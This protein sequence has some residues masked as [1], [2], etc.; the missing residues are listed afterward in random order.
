MPLAKSSG[1]IHSSSPVRGRFAVMRSPLGSPLPL[2]RHSL[3]LDVFLVQS[4]CNGDLDCACR[5][6]L[7][8]HDNH[9]FGLSVYVKKKMFLSCYGQQKLTQFS[10][11][12][13]DL[14]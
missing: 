11:Y 12:V 2:M 1:S 7:R 9:S 10:P 13:R 3:C 14:T 4:S 6:T 8:V 5:A